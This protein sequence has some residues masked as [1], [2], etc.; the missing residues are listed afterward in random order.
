MKDLKA[1]FQSHYHPPKSSMQCHTSIPY[2]KHNAW[3]EPIQLIPNTEPLPGFT[4]L[5]QR[6]NKSTSSFNSPSADSIA[7]QLPFHTSH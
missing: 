3:T 4:S 2:T 1:L 6:G 7:V 5:S